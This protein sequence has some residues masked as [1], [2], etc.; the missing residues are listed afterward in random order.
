MNLHQLQLGAVAVCCTFAGVTLGGIDT[1][2]PWTGTG[3]TGNSTH[4]HWEFQNPN[5]PQVGVGSG[6]PNSQPPIVTGGTWVPTIGANG[7]WGLNPGESI[8]IDLANFPQPNDFK[9]IWI[10]YHLIGLAGALV[11]PPVIQVDSGGI[12]GLP[13]GTPTLTPTPDGGLIGAQGFRFPFNPAFEI[14]HIFNASN[15]PMF[16][17]WLTIDTICAPTPGATAIMLLGGVAV[18]RRRR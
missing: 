17:E 5:A 9:L 10:Q 1:P 18:T 15:T 2:P 7:A 6:P 4:W 13:Y 12:P 3:I 14:I 16:F 11:T 8:T